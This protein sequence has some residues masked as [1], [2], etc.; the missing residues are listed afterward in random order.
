MKARR[1]PSSVCRTTRQPLVLG[2]WQVSVLAALRRVGRRLERPCG[3]FMSYRSERKLMETPATS[4]TILCIQGPT[5]TPGAAQTWHERHIVSR[6]LYT[7]AELVG[8]NAKL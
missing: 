7:C 2:I 5:C 6:R 8:A 4:P 3:T 1:L